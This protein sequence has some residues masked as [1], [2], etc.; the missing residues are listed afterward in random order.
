MAEAA[1]GQG[2]RGVGLPHTAH[3]EKPIQETIWKLTQLLLSAFTP[4]DWSLKTTELISEAANAP[5]KV[6]FHI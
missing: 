3:E 1:L 6:L 2:T 4:G 5:K